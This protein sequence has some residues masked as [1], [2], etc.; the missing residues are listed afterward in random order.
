MIEHVISMRY[1]RALI[2]C[3]EDDREL[4]QT[5]NELTTILNVISENPNLLH[6]SENKSVHSGDKVKIFNAITEKLSVSKLVARFILILVKKGRLGLINRIVKDFHIFVDERFGRI[7]AYVKT[8]VP[9]TDKQISDLKGFYCEKLNKK[10][11]NIKEEIDTNMLGG[12][13]VK[14]GNI[15]YDGT[16]ETKLLK[17]KEFLL[18]E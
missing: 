3:I 16:V 1:A 2:E 15:T 18:K 5:T 6:I 10:D 12:M 17:L 13:T 14:I 7:T 4:D 11:M 8:P 9:L